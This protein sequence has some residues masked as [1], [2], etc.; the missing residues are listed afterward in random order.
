MFIE[1]TAQFLKDIPGSLAG[2]PRSFQFVEEILQ[3]PRIKRL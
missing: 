3:F 2:G 1:D